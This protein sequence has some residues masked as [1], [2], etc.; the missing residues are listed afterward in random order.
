M[1]ETDAI[2]EMLETCKAVN[3]RFKTSHLWAL[4]NQPQVGSCLPITFPLREPV[5]IILL[6]GLKAV[7]NSGSARHRMVWSGT[8]REAGNERKSVRRTPHFFSGS[9]ASEPVGALAGFDTSS[10]ASEPVGALAGFELDRPR[11][12]PVGALAGFDSVADSLPLAFC[13]RSR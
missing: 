5:R 11:S 1:L 9:S 6:R 8:K 12:E 3:G 7:C 2:V 4:Q 13:C 10:S